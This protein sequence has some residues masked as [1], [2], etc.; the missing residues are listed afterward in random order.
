MLLVWVCH[1]F[2]R[3]QLVLRSTG[4]LGFQQSPFLI[5]VVLVTHMIDDLGLDT[6]PLA[7]DASAKS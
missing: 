5:K 1:N 7:E 2:Y 4:Y 6:F 3:E